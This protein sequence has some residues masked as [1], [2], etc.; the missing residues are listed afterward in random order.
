MRLVT[1][2]VAA[3]PAWCRRS[4]ELIVAAG[5]SRGQDDIGVRNMKI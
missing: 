2:R 4:G 1:R 5:R 3:R